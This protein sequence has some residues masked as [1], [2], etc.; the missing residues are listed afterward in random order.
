MSLFPA[1]FRPSVLLLLPLAMLALSGCL[2][3]AEMENRWAFSCQDGFEFTA[4]YARD[5]DHVVLEYL[6]ESGEQAEQD[7]TMEDQQQKLKLKRSD[8]ASG[9]RYTNEGVVFWSKGSLAMIELN[10]EP[11]H[12]D[13]QGDNF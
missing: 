11:W 2:T 7:Q 12:K 6:L 5:G 8:A 10:G 13:C 4:V 1:S 9:A 3:T